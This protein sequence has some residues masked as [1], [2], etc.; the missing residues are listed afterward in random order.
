MA[1]KSWTDRPNMGA[2]KA[3]YCNGDDI[4]AAAK[5]PTVFY[6]EVEGSKIEIPNMP[7]YKTQSDFGECIAYSM[8]TLL[9]K[10]SC[11]VWKDSMPDCMHPPAKYDYSYFA[12]QIYTNRLEKNQ[13]ETYRVKISPAATG[14]KFPLPS[15]YQIFQWYNRDDLIVEECRPFYKLTEKFSLAG[16]AGRILL[17]SFLVYLKAEY[18]IHI[19]QNISAEEEKSILEKIEN[20]TG[21]DKKY[22]DVRKAFLIKNNIAT[23]HASFEGFMYSLLFDGCQRQFAADGYDVQ[24]YPDDATIAQDDDII[25]RAIVELKK[26]HPIIISSVCMR[27]YKDSGNCDESHTLVISGYKTVIAV[28]NKKEVKRLF[29]VHNSWGQKWQNAYNG[30]WVDADNLVSYIYRPEGRIG[31]QTLIWLDY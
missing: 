17:D 8:G 3:I 11:D 31:S 9:Q 27:G 23:G 4:S 20:Y 29:K 13:T 12:I 22:F 21:I 24:A 19:G 7:A 10:H 2:F 1:Q 6:K 18:D 26:S 16:Q 30:G 28:N 15:I 25:N 14:T 5:K